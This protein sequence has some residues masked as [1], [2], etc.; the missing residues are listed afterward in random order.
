MPSGPKR[1]SLKSLWV[2]TRVRDDAERRSD[3]QNMRS[4]H[5]HHVGNGLALGQYLREV[6]GAEDVTQGGLGEKAGRVMGVLDVRYRHGGVADAVIDNRVDRH[7][8][9]V[10]R[11]HLPDGQSINRSINRSLSRI[12]YKRAFLSPKLHSAWYSITRGSAVAEKP[13]DAQYY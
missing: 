1:T 4:A 7:R 13:R 3:D 10:L 5:L 2:I 8:H 12:C 6:L 11:Q 9:R